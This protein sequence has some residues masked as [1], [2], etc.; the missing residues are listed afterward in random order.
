MEIIGNRSN[1]A[2]TF[3]PNLVRT[4]SHYFCRI[5][6][7]TDTTPFHQNFIVVLVYLYL[8]H[9][10]NQIKK[11]ILSLELGPFKKSKIL[12]KTRCK[13]CLEVVVE[14]F[15]FEKTADLHEDLVTMLRFPINFP[16]GG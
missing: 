9:T 7:K 11:L 1:E 8:N 14:V 13:Y 16:V 5:F 6:Q 10:E 4:I 15:R 3:D 12:R 2:V